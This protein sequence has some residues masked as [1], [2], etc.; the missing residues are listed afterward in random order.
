[1]ASA[2]PFKI[3]VSD[4]VLKSI[5]SKLEDARFPRELD[6]PSDQKWSY[7]APLDTVKTLVSYWKDSFEWRDIESRLNEMP[8]FTADVSAPGQETINVHFVHKRSP[9]PDAIPFLFVHGWPGNFTEVEKM[10]P[11]LTEPEDGKQAYHVVAPSLPGFTFSSMPTKPG[12]DL[13]AIAATFNQL[14]LDLGYATYIG[15][16][17][18]WG[19][20]VCRLLAAEHP[21]HCMAI[22]VNMFVTPPPSKYNPFEVVKYLVGGY[23]ALE[24]EHLKQTQHFNETETG[25][26]AIQG[27]KPQTLNYALT[28]SPVGMLAWIRE[29]L[30]TWTDEYPWTSDEILTWVMLYYVNA[31]PATHIYKENVRSRARMV[32]AHISNPVG[33]SIFP[34]ELYKVP[35][36]WAERVAHIISWSVHDRG[37]HFAAHETPEVLVAD[38]Q[39]FVAKLKSSKQWTQKA[40]F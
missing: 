36:S 9:R 38:V 19:S 33:V 27:S 35:R 13:Y 37:G 29:K 4:D 10:L 1:M 16:G 14:M 31:Q 34:K 6:L 15:Q 40:K 23:S 22:H 12:F 26:Q 11:L 32:R 18:D 30:E 5:K 7:G 39:E 21:D 25:Y 28:D 3:D 2:K 20:F 17:G 24:L 8:Q